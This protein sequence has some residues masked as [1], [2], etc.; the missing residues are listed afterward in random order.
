MSSGFPDALFVM[1]SCV[2]VSPVVQ[3]FRANL[4]KARNR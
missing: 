4:E 3:G 1:A 2:L